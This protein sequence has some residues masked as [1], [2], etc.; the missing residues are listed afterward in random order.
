MMAQTLQRHIKSTSQTR[1]QPSAI[2]STP[3]QHRLLVELSEA[4]WCARKK[5]VVV[6]VGLVVCQPATLE[7]CKECYL[8]HLKKKN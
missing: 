5:H 4:K 2:L 1:K 7:I 6:A 8:L 3:S